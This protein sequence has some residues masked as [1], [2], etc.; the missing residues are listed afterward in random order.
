MERY[1]PQEVLKGPPFSMG[2]RN[3]QTLYV[4]GQA[5]IDPSTNTVAGPDLDTQ[6]AFTMRNIEEVLARAGMTLGDVVQA[7]V[8]LA[9]RSLYVP[10]NDLYK[11]YFREPYPARTVVYCELNYDLL[12]EID[13]VASA[14]KDKTYY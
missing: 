11:T 3:G 2:V 13:V 8:Y 12:V 10:F 1:S 7:T 9:D 14:E 4:S 6:V 5:G